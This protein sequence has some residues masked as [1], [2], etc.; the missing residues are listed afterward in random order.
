M[1]NSMLFIVVQILVT[2]IQLSLV[3]H[4][5]NNN[6]KKSYKN[7]EKISDLGICQ[8]QWKSKYLEDD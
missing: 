2:F 6:N 4:R 8:A 5:N 3:I 7:F 1:L